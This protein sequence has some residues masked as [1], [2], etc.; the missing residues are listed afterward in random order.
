ME[1]NRNPFKS[2]TPSFTS[3]P[4]F[5][6]KKLTAIA[7]LPP[8]TSFEPSFEDLKNFDNKLNPF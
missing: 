4:V 3:T 6:E 2:T 1:E 5:G 7:D 8:L